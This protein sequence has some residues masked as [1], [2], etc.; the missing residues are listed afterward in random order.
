[1]SIGRE[2]RAERRRQESLFGPNSAAHPGTMTHEMRL[3]ILTEE[4]GEAAH[5]LTE[6]HLYPLGVAREMERLR[7]ELV[8]VAAVAVAWIEALDAG[9][10]KDRSPPA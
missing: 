10:I 1:M 4:V 8:Q 9:K 6:A 3:A 5:C 2:I 7:V